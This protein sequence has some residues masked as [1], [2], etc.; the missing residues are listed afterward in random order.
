MNK[1]AGEG[2]G[3]EGRGVE[4]SGQVPWGPSVRS[5]TACYYSSLFIFF[6]T[7]GKELSGKVIKRGFGIHHARRTHYF[8][9]VIKEKLHL[10]LNEIVTV[11]KK[12]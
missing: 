10:N 11:L 6:F 1:G 2:K 8:C 4:C 5:A 9:T 3:G 7:S 12:G